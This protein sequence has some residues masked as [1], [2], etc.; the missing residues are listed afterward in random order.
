MQQKTKRVLH[1][2]SLKTLMV[3]LDWGKKEG[4]WRGI[5]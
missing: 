4:E 3:C 1:D 2:E 5:E